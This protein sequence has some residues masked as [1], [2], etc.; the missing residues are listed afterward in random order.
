MASG[1]A[2]GTWR[3]RL[4][5]AGGEAFSYRQVKNDEKDAADLAGSLR[6]GL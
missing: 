1:W 4:S 5:P 3:T 2:R 6:M